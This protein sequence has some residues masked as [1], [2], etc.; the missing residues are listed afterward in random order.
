MGKYFWYQGKMFLNIEKAL[1]KISEDQ[2]LMHYPIDFLHIFEIKV[3][4]F[5]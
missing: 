4:N 5:D 3:S 1:V 2:P